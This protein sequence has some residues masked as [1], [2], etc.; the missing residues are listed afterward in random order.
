MQCLQ[1]TKPPVHLTLYS[2]IAEQD[3]EILKLLHLGHE[4][5]PKQ[6]GQSTI[7]WLRTI[8]VDPHP[9]YF[10]HTNAIL[11][12][13]NQ[14]LSLPQLRFEIL[15]THIINRIGS[16]EKVC[17]VKEV[18]HCCMTRTEFALFLLNTKFNNQSVPPFQHPGINFPR[19]AE[20]CDTPIIGAHP[21]VSR[22]QPL[23]RSLVPELPLCVEVSPTISSWYLFTYCTSSMFPCPC[24]AF[25]SSSQIYN[26]PHPISLPCG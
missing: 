25:A 7:C 13:P 21:P 12:F 1:Y 19:E 16:R 9:D 23:S 6:R 22:V 17:R 20:D 11:S 5:R 2:P 3:P 8:V 18:I 4:L 24:L 10:T 14:T 15:S 26:A